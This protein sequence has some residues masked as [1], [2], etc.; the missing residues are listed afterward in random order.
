MRVLKSVG[1]PYT[2]CGSSKK[3]AQLWKTLQMPSNII[4]YS[5]FCSSG[6]KT[7]CERKVKLATFCLSEVTPLF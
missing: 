2:R 6:Y 7:L 4:T 3:L 1:K 5:C